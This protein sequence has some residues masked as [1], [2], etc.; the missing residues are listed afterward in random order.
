VKSG[1]KKIS[2]SDAVP[3]ILLIAL[4][5]HAVFEGIVL[6]LETEMA[7][8]LAIIFAILIHKGVEGICLGISLVKTYPDDFNRIRLLVIVFSLATPVGVLIGIFA[9][10]A[11]ETAH[12]IMS[13]LVAGTFVYISCNEILVE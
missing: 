5:T 11:G 1:E 6:G 4:S 10:G 12:V 3:Y 13:S 2:R 9:T 7:S 8:V